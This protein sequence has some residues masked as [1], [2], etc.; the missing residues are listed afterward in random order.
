MFF[1]RMLVATVLVTLSQGLLADHVERNISKLVSTGNMP[2]LKTLVSQYQKKE[3][4]EIVERLEQEEAVGV[5]CLFLD[6]LYSLRAYIETL[7]PSDTQV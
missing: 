7:E 1:S 5:S 3:M 2:E 4:L 6:T